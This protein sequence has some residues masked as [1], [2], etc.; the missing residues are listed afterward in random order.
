MDFNDENLKKLMQLCRIH[1]PEEERPKLRE[2][3]SRILEYMQQLSDLDTKD[4]P[5]CNYV[6]SDKELI[7]RED[8]AVDTMSR[9]DFLENAADQV[10]GMVRVPPV[11]KF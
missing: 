1:S 2:N 3:L 6:I 7:L 8:D 5:P 4:V 9:E 11:I 10:G